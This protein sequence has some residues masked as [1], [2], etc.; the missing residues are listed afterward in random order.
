MG[1]GIGLE[2]KKC[3]EEGEEG[4]PAIRTALFAYV[5]QF[6][7][8]LILSTVNYCQQ[9]H[10]SKTSAYLSGWLTFCG[11]LVNWMYSL[12]WLI[13]KVWKMGKSQ[14][15]KQ[16]WGYFSVE[17]SSTPNL[18]SRVSH[19]PVSKSGETLV[20]NLEH[21]GGVLCNQAVCCIALCR[22]QSITLWPPLP[23]TVAFG[24]K[25]WMVSFSTFIL[26][27]C[28]SVSMQFTVVMM[29]LPS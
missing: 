10:Q 2:G 28:K 18:V 5:H 24:L 14:H 27:L 4:I 7:C 25:F 9:V 23:A 6:S 8:N 11:N 26:R 17:M 20:G 3:K 22:I 19:H 21:Q 13:S 12:E 1:K 15:K 29:S 16:P